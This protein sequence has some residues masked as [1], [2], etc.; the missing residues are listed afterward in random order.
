MN[1]NITEIFVNS[2]AWLSLMTTLPYWTSRFDVL[3]QKYVNRKVS[4]FQLFQH[5]TEF[6]T[7]NLKYFNQNT[8]NSKYSGS[9]ASLKVY[10]TKKNVFLVTLHIIQCTMKTQFLEFYINIYKNLRYQVAGYY[11][12]TMGNMG[13]FI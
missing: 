3:F 10:K 4:F 9:L 5:P 12:K 13:T 6:I 1:N 2:Y 11:T 8:K 7:L